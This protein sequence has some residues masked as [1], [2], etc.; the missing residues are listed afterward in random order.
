MHPLLPAQARAEVRP[1]LALRGAGARRG[2]GQGAEA[3]VRADAA[4]AGR[5]G[6]AG[7]LLQ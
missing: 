3:S 6:G 2:V 1:L 5:A 4:E 7:R